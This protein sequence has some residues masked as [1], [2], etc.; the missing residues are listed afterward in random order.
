MDTG[1]ILAEM[2]LNLLVT[3]AAY[4]LVPTIL[5]L[6]GKEFKAKT[7][8]RIIIINCIIVWLAFRIV[9]I[10]MGKEPG[11]GAAVIVWGS[12]GYLLLKKFCLKEEK[13]EVCTSQKQEHH[14]SVAHVCL[15]AE[16]EAPRSYG[17][18]NTLGSDIMLQEN[19]EE[20]KKNAPITEPTVKV[21]PK[22]KPTPVAKKPVKYCSRCG[23]PI[24]G[25][26]KKCTGCGKQYFKGI[27][28]KTVLNIIIA[29]LLSVSLVGVFILSRENVKL[30]KA[31]EELVQALAV[32][33]NNPEITSN[34]DTV[35]SELK[36]EI[37]ALKADIT[38]LNAQK[39]E[40]QRKLSEYADEIAFYDKYIV[41]VA[42]DGTKLYHNYDCKKFQLCD[43][44][45]VYG[46]E[47]AESKG[48]K[49]CSLCID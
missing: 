20:P 48:Y 7:L 30:Q 40:I 47:E 28:M 34:L 25:F 35:N 4:L 8:K 27:T 42:D 19:A 9:Q 6:T 2:S 24:D 31:N 3:I 43:S 11:S 13:Q 1:N 38:E 10:E 21:E 18:F 12:V 39:N 15:L 37:K 44:F 29:I 26:S 23:K 36:K 45:W 22:H 49:P 32:D 46:F 5:A 14:E 33:Q 17:T 16:D 41:F